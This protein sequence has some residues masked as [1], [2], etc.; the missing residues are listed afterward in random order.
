MQKSL[1]IRDIECEESKLLDIQNYPFLNR[2]DILVES[3]ECFK[4]GITKA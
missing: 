1:I 2:V 4:L 3:H